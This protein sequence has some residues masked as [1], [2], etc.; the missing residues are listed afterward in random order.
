R[1]L[2]AE[3]SDQ[4]D[5]LLI[6]DQFE[7]VFTLCQDPAERAAFIAM[8]LHAATTPTSRTRVVLGVRAD[9]YGHCGQ[10]PQLVQALNDA[11][12]L[13]G[14]MSIAELT[15]AVTLPA[16]QAGYTLDTAL[17]TRLVSEASG[18]ACALPLLSHALVETWRRRRGTR[19]TLAGY[20]AAGGIRHAVAR[21]A[22]D[23]HTRL[24]PDEQ[25][26]ARRIFLRLTAPADGT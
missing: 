11:Q 14:P 18:Q 17:A 8:L 13:I 26:A 6:V 19:L 5:L 16:R 21:T 2:L 3:R 25:Q 12:V 9:F 23:L 22:E 20:E 4:A 10:Y 1:Q 15:D 7:E 24:N